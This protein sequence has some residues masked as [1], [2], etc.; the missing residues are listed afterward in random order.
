MS[1]NTVLT[2]KCTRPGCGKL[3]AD[4]NKGPECF[5]HPAGRRRRPRP[6][7]ANELPTELV[8]VPAGTI[9]GAVAKVFKVSVADLEG[10]SQD[11]ELGLARRICMYLLRADRHLSLPQIARLLR[12]PNWSS[13]TS[14]Y[15]TIAK[16]ADEKIL[17]LIA[18][19]RSHYAPSVRAS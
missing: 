12:R 3:L 9:I 5:R 4:L 14:A 15:R 1:E 7:L 8:S 16:T 2:R 6:M 13:A 19:I 18:E 17:N 10:K 11:G